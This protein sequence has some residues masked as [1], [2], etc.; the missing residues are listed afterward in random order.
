MESEFG[1]ESF[2]ATVIM[3]VYL[4]FWIILSK[5]YKKSIQPNCSHEFIAVGK[6]YYRNLFLLFVYDLLFEI[7]IAGVFIHTNPMIDLAESITY[8]ISGIIYAM[9][10]LKI[11]KILTFPV[12]KKKF[13][14]V[15]AILIILNSI[16]PYIISHLYVSGYFGNTGMYQPYVLYEHSFFI[17]YL[18]FILLQI[19]VIILIFLNA[20]KLKKLKKIYFTLCLGMVFCFCA[21]C[22]LLMI[23]FSDIN[24][25]DIKEGYRI[26][27]LIGQTIFLI[28]IIQTG[29]ITL[30]DKTF[31]YSKQKER[32]P[33]YREPQYGLPQYNTIQYSQ[34]LQ[35]D[36][37]Q[38]YKS[39]PSL[40]KEERHKKIS[41][42]FK[43]SNRVRIQ[44]VS[45]ILGISRSEL[46]SILEDDQSG[47]SG[48]KIEEDD[49]VATG[50]GASKDNIPGFLNSI[51]SQFDNWGDNENTKEGKV[52]D[53]EKF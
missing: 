30:P 49:L 38:Q 9:L 28:G 47:L 31:N 33:Q 52:E 41:A 4:V 13:G 35:R 12:S 24:K 29:K 19:G 40:S 21:G 27:S 36:L 50:D 16:V 43:I 17:Y 51:D 3:F 48:F 26:L 45:N 53:F 5:K 2:F 23:Y 46:F 10:V 25:W 7:F 8:L 15:W 39:Q 11:D 22:Y 34:P 1:Q 42:L 44:D 14:K 37:N 20:A 18:I 6:Q 32:Q